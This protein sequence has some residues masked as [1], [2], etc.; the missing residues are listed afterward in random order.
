MPT[1]C[2]RADRRRHSVSS[3]KRDEFRPIF[4]LVV[5]SWGLAS[6]RGSSAG[7]AKRV[8]NLIAKSGT[9]GVRP[10]IAHRQ[11]NQGAARCDR[12]QAYG[13]YRVGGDGLVFA[14]CQQLRTELT[15]DALR[16][17]QVAHGLV[18]LVDL[19]RAHR[20]FPGVWQ[21][22]VSPNKHLFENAAPKV[23]QRPDRSTQQFKRDPAENGGGRNCHQVY[24]PEHDTRESYLRSAA[25]QCGLSGLEQMSPSR[26]VVRMPGPPAA[27]GSGIG[28]DTT[29]TA[30]N[31]PSRARPKLAS[32]IVLIKSRTP[33]RASRAARVAIYAT[34][35]GGLNQP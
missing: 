10:G 6:S 23:K 3:S 7:Q 12:I 33:L 24:I 28:A 35:A 30:N 20:R 13:S 8:F 31:A 21:W 9:I 27:A 16:L 32:Q 19:S 26:A 11:P 22:D 4:D 5:V 2:G 29:F 15:E 17:S 14:E 1:T 34:A 18:I 25:A